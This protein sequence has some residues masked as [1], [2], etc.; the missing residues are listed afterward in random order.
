[1]GSQPGVGSTYAGQFNTTHWSVVFRANGSQTESAEAALHQVC[2]NYWH[3]L[4]AHCRRRG[5]S[6]HDAQDLTQDFFT[7]L[8][9][10]DYLRMA[11]PER[12]RFRSFLL[13]SLDHFLI[14]E[15]V[16]GKS[17]KRGGGKQ[18]VSLDAEVA[19]G[20]YR[21]RSTA[22]EFTPEALFD[23][24]WALTLLDRA[25]KRLSGEYENS[26][27]SELFTRLKPFLLREGGATAFKSIARGTGLTEGAFKVAV[28]RLRRRF[29]LAVRHEVAQTVA[30]EA[31]ISDEM[32]YL[33]AALRAET[34]DVA[35]QN[36]AL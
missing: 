34:D 10:K 25:M 28:H 24:G 36:S 8:L 14:N 20:L 6:P 30:T 26:G 4:Y 27:K 11:S 33:L 1:M 13:K 5:N 17:L 32:A 29:S 31:E 22:G 12:G 19:E 15:W 35:P 16:R 9:E 2:S 18:I 7:R 23:K 21:E 3:P